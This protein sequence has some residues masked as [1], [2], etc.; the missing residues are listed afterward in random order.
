VTQARD[1]ALKLKAEVFDN[2]KKWMR[3][4]DIRVLERA[5]AAE[6]ERDDLKAQIRRQLEPAS[7]EAESVYA[8]GRVYPLCFAVGC[9]AIATHG[10]YCEGHQARGVAPS[11]ASVAAEEHSRKL[12]S[13]N[14][15]SVPDPTKAQP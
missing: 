6:R 11:A 14:D 3:W 2:P 15:L 8:N 7:F 13:S 10:K 12:A 5:E 4:C 1:E 9:G